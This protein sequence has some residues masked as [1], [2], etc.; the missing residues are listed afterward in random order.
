MGLRWSSRE[1]SVV[2]LGWNS[3]GLELGWSSR[4]CS[5]VEGWSSGGLWWSSGGLGHRKK[6]YRY[7]YTSVNISQ[8]QT[9]QIL[10]QEGP[11]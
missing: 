3:G 2:E 1:C 5:E 7:L 9:A 8:K 10:T 6:L 4:E 11:V